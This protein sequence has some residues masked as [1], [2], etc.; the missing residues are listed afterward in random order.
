M[1]AHVPKSVRSPKARNVEGLKGQNNHFLHGRHRR[2]ARRITHLRLQQ[3]S[4][5]RLGLHLL[6]QLLTYNGHVNDTVAC[7]QQV[8][9]VL[10]N[11][12]FAPGRA[13]NT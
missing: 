1:V 6:D 7:L 12:L 9:N 8:Y 5:D 11:A 10:E 2:S 3:P 13:D 4:W